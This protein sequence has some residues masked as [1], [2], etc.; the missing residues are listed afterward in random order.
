MGD[1]NEM[2]E[3]ANLYNVKSGTFSSAEISYLEPL[4]L[5]YD[6]KLDKMES[7]LSTVYEDIKDMEKKSETLIEENAFLRIELEQKCE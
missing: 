4:L 1:Y 5:A 7:M 6:E 3:K 2:K